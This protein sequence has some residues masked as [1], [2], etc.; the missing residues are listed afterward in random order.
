VLVINTSYAMTE[1]TDAPVFVRPDRAEATVGAPRCGAND[2]Q[3]V[4]YALDMMVP[5]MA[6]H[7]LDRCWVDARPGTEGWQAFWSVFSF[8][9]KLVTSLALLTYSGVLKPKEDV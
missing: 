6:L 5:V 9:G 7:Q 4:F 2:I 3:P 1:V 8:V